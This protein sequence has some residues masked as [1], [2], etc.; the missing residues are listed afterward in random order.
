MSE[1]Y[2]KYRE[3]LMYLIFGGLTTL[4]NIVVFYI[5]KD[6]LAMDY[7]ASNGIAWFISVLFAF[8]T[9]KYFVFSSNETSK[10]QFIKEMLLFFWYRLLSLVIDMGMMIVMVSVLKIDALIAKL[11]T[12]VVIVVIN[13][14]FSKLFIFKPK[15]N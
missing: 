12:Q 3:V 2:T 1:L 9:N 10:N 8:I 15:K 11:I 14:V 7:R 13:Y 6:L 5:F 4:I